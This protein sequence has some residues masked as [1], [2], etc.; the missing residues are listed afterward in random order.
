MAAAAQEMQPPRLTHIH[1]DWDAVAADLGAIGRHGRVRQPACRHRRHRRAIDR[2]SQWRDRGA[3][4]RH[5]RQPGAGP[6]ALR[7]RRLPG[8]SRRRRDRQARRRLSFRLPSLAVLPAGPGGLRRRVHRQGQR[9]ARARHQL[10]RTDQRLRLRLCAA[11]RPCRAGRHGGAAGQGARRRIPRASGTSSSRTTR[12]TPS[13]A[14]ACPTWS[15]SCASTAARA[16]A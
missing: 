7:H 2:R 8:R 13:S 3:V 9:D 11:L 5:R 10:F 12:A 15:R 16:I 4:S 1:P 6:A 14:M